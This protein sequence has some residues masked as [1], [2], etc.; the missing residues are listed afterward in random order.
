MLRYAFVGVSTNLIGYL[1]Y[2]LI[3]YI[4]LGPKVTM[5]LLYVTGATL[6]FWGNRTITFRHHEKGLAV[7]LRYILAHGVGYLINLTLLYTLGDRLGYAHQLVQAFAIFVVAGFL[8]V[9]F[10]YFVFPDPKR[11]LGAFR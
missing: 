10:K 11:S 3:T 9:A 8:F 4:G 2:L 5:T 1:V 6:G 7:G